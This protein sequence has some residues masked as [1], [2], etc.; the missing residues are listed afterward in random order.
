GIFVKFA[1]DLEGLVFSGEVDK[2]LMASLKSGD[3]LKVKI[4]KVDPGAA[5]IGLS[6]NIG[7]PSAE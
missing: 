7:Q 6:A 2:D 5:K 3:K 4:I 1:E